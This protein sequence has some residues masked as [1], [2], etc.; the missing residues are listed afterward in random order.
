MCEAT[1]TFLARRE[2]LALL[3]SDSPP[4]WAR[5]YDEICVVEYLPIG[6]CDAGSSDEICSSTADACRDP[7]TFL[8]VNVTSSSSPGCFVDQIGSSSS[9]S[10]ESLYGSCQRPNGKSY[11][12]WSKDDCSTSS[13][14]GSKSTWSPASESQN[15]S[16]YQT[17]T[18]ACVKR[19]NEE[20]QNQYFCA[21]SANACDNATEYWNVS[22]LAA[23]GYSCRLCDL[24]QAPTQ[25]PPPTSTVEIDS[26]SSNTQS[27][28]SRRQDRTYVTASVASSVGVLLIA[29]IV[30][31]L[32]KKPPLPP[33]LTNT[34]GQMMDLSSMEDD[35]DEM[36]SLSSSLPTSSLA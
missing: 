23:A 4:I 5:K 8:T 22:Q 30:Y 35:E 25:P 6:L 28:S 24:S 3:E 17:N 34:T 26:P 16:C 12:L 33:L 19:H 11:C 7:H 1:E 31:R 18:G 29:F 20:H 9:S 10:S 2:I 13:E 21:V 32:V 15:C 27:S 14:D 36:S